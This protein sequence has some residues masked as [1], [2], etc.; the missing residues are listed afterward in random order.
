MEAASWWVREAAKALKAL[1][2]TAAPGPSGFRNARLRLI[3]L[4]RGGAEL[5]AQ[6][7]TLM[8]MGKVREEAMR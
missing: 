2:S 7:A 1:R 5:F 6:W 8:G 3:S 4:H